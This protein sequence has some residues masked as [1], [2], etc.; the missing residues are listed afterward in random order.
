[1]DGLHKNATLGAR[2]L[3]ERHGNVAIVLTISLP[4]KGLETNVR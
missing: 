1:M 4:M 2:L 3:A